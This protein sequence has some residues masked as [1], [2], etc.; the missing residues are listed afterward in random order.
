MIKKA[1]GPLSALWTFSELP[2]HTQESMIETIHSFIY[3]LF[4]EPGHRVPRTLLYSAEKSRCCYC[5]QLVELLFSSTRRSAGIRIYSA[6]AFCSVLPHASS[7][8]HTL[9]C[10]SW[11]Y[12]AKKRKFMSNAGGSASAVHFNGSHRVSAIQFQ[13][14]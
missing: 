1:L 2:Y 14:H 7:H 9:S 5:A 4:I 3:F 6:C 12:F 11:R 8:L 13:Y 10:R